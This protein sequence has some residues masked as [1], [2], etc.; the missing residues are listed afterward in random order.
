[1][2]VPAVAKLRRLLDSLPREALPD[3]L[4]SIIRTSNKEKLQ[5]APPAGGQ[6]CAATFWLGLEGEHT[7]T[8]GRGHRA[9]GGGGGAPRSS[10]GASKGDGCRPHRQH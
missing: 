1:M 9:G 3:I 4:T 8:S 5:V 2:S 10:Y 7:W 6:A